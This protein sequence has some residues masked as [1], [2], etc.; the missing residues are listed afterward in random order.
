M[1]KHNAINLAVQCLNAAKSAP[2]EYF[3]WKHEK[4]LDSETFF[5]SLVHIQRFE[6]FGNFEL[7][8]P[9]EGCHWSSRICVSE[10]NRE[11]TKAW[12]AMNTIKKKSEKSS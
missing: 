4:F 9:S 3:K 7:H 5:C 8:F 12:E 11:M 1:T 10:T 6:P 2:S